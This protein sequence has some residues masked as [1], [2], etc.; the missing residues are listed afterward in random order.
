MTIESTLYSTLSADATVQG[1]VSDLTVSPN[2]HRIF[3]G[4]VPDNAAL[5]YVAYQVITHTAFN[6]LSGAPDTQRKVA[7]INCISNDYDEAKS[8]AEACRAALDEIGYQSGG[9]DD[10]FPATQNYRTTIDFAFI[11]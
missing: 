7:Q 8:L 1:L 2:V 4:F 11:A 3:T 5:P 9:S 10:Y 6:K